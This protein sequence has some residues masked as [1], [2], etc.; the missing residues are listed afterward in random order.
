MDK[1]LKSFYNDSETRENVYNYL[2][3]FC[4]QEALKELFE[5]ESES[6]VQNSINIRN[7]KK[8]IDKAFE[9]MD[10]LFSGKVAKKEPINEAR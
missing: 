5:G 6:P 4:K 1:S 3:E 9:N 8:I 2:V 7:G 10:L